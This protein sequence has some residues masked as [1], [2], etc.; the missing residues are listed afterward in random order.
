MPPVLQE[1][2]IYNSAEGIESVS[3]DGTPLKR[4]T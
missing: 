2:Y 3:L 4:D 1:L